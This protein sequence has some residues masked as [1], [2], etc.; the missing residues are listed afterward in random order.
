MKK[1]KLINLSQNALSQIKGGD[2]GGGGSAPACSCSCDCGGSDTTHQQ[3]Y[4][5]L[6]SAGVTGPK[7]G[8]QY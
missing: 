3:T 1:L 6:Q 5:N 4:S 8:L 7:N 2:Q